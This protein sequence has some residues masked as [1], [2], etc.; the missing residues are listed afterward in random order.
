VEGHRLTDDELVLNC[1]S[2][3]LGAVVTTS[4]VISAT[5]MG[6][7]EQHGGEGHW[8]L[9]TPVQPAVEEAL[10]WSSPVTHFMRRARR[11]TT[12]YGEIIQA[13]EAVIAWI[14]SANRDETVFER[15]HEIDLGRAH[16]RHV[17]FGV[18][19]HRCL[20]T[21]LARLMLRESFTELIASIESFELAGPPSHLVSNEIAGM[22]SLPL[23]V[24]LRPGADLVS[25]AF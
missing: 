20:G 25:K 16:N 13:G 17:A 8:S 12:I 15:P 2:L 21:H 10:R 14:G 22:V 11:D 7:A 23:K 4:Q 24:I 5:F 6:L 3:L 18:G 1:L 9:A 19:P